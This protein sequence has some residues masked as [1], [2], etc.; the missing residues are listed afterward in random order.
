MENSVENGLNWNQAEE[1]RRQNRFAEA[2]PIFIG[3]FEENQDEAT[4]WRI[5]H[6]ARHS[7][8][9][10]TAVSYLEKHHNSFPD[11]ELLRTQ[12][13]WLRYD[14]FLQPVKKAGNHSRVIEIAD[15]I[16]PLTSGSKDILFNLTLFAAIDAA[17]SL[18]DHEKMLD[19]TEKVCPAALD[20]SVREYKGKK[21]I[22]W[23]ERWYFARLHALFA[24]GN[25]MEC[26]GLAHKA[27]RE[28]PRKLEFAR[29]SALCLEKLGR[30]DEG[31]EE[32]Q[33]I[34]KTRGAPWYVFADVARI[35]FE[36]NEFM[37]ALGYALKGAGFRGDLKTKVNLFTLIG[38]I[39]LVLGEREKAKSFVLLACAI[40]NSEHWKFND[41][42][43]EIMGRLD[44]ASP[45]PEVPNAW[46]ECRKHTEAQK[47]GNA[48]RPEL[49]A[50][51]EGGHSEN[52][53]V[54][55]NCEGLLELK[56]P[57]SPF[58]FIKSFQFE[59]MVYVKTQEIPEDLRFNGAELRF[60]VV[61]SFDHKRERWGN[62]AVEIKA[63]A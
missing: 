4:L 53:V 18:E 39:F 45:F 27:F 44:I 16:L 3:C 38:K 47:E 42:L 14:A 1:L 49:T 5:I 54:A 40:R 50:K 37:Q 21:M 28:F 9:Y 2:L 46:A 11:S 57:D 32:L 52:R 24:A 56:K 7:H 48:P 41:E 23:R 17:R 22:S 29:K 36:K 61:E 25:Y 20:E 62:R 30:T 10:E 26:R 58:A 63:A 55:S 6:C 12:F 8:D 13:A 35:L 33:A 51:V 15:E 34:S 43:Q 19:L 31:L 59:N 60:N